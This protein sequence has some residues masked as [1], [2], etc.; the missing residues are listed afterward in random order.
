MRYNPYSLADRLEKAGILADAE[1]MSALQG[2][3]FDAIREMRPADFKLLWKGVFS[4]YYHE[5]VAEA[6]ELFEQECY[7]YDTKLGDIGVDPRKNFKP[8]TEFEIDQE[9]EAYFKEQERS[10]NPDNQ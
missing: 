7:E 5:L 3:D 6:E 8:K 1:I 4:L 10:T 9:I 2:E